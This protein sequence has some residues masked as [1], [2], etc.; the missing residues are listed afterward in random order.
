MYFEVA[1]AGLIVP[2]D[3]NRG[4]KVNEEIN[5]QLLN[6]VTR[7]TVCELWGGAIVIP[8]FKAYRLSHQDER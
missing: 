1:S 5:S 7:T 3:V 2:V 4:L 6:I 8:A